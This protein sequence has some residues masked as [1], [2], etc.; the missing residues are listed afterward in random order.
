MDV[1]AGS[2]YLNEDYIYGGAGKRKAKRTKSRSRPRTRSRSIPWAFIDTGYR[3]L[4]PS[5]KAEFLFAYDNLASPSAFNALLRNV[6]SPPAAVPQ[7]SKT[8]KDAYL[9]GHVLSFNTSTGLP[10]VQ[11]R[12]NKEAVNGVLHEIPKGTSDQLDDY[13]RKDD[14]DDWKVKREPV[15]VLVPGKGKAKAFVILRGPPEAGTAAPLIHA[16]DL[17][18]IID[19]NDWSNAWKEK[20][21]GIPTA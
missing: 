14:S 9:Q 11:P 18:E 16:D 15:E 12:P 21:R 4:A 19:S 8:V 6:V 1:F 5:E 20:L 7:V 10:T 2:R 13:L 17:K 3:I